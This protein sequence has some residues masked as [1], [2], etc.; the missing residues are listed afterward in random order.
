MLGF[1]V[2]EALPQIISVVFALPAH[3]A[4][5]LL[6]GEWGNEPVNDLP[7]SGGSLEMVEGPLLGPEL[8]QARRAQ[9]TGDVLPERAAVAVQARGTRGEG[10][11]C[12]E[13]GAAGRARNLR[14]L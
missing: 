8:T 4:L 7:A 6:H 9:R 13:A 1:P 2:R 10:R 3:D 11:R 5:D 12:L 14:P